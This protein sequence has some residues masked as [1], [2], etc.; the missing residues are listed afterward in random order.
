[1]GDEKLSVP[2]KSAGD[3]VHAVT[4]AGLSAIPVV[5]GPA[6]ELFQLVLQP[7]LEKRREAWMARVGDAIAKL[8]ADGLQLESLR[9][10]EEFVSVVMQASQIAIR[11]HQEEKLEML[12]NAVVNVATGQTTDEALHTMFLNFVDAFTGWHVSILRLFQSPRA[13]PGIMTGGLSHVLENSFPELRGQRE[14]S[15]RAWRQSRG[16]RR[17]DRR[18][19]PPHRRIRPRARNGPSRR[20]WRWLPAAG[21]RCPCRVRVWPQTKCAGRQ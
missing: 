21:G 8:E 10:N 4:K 16:G 7:P 18:R 6:V 19:S 11:T 17:W 2:K 5:G 9:E 15:A 3:L 20:T 14:S 1:V 13:P 12:R